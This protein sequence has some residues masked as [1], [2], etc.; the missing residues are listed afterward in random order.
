MTGWRFVISWRWAGYFALV[1]VFAIASCG[2]GNWQFDRRAQAQTE[3]QRIQ[4]NYEAD[5]VPVAEVLPQLDAWSDDLK[6]TPV[7][8][9][10][11]YL[12]DE[13]ILVRGRP[14][15]GHP[16]FEVLTPLQLDDGSV[17]V[18]NRG[19]V[20]I[21]SRQDNPDVVPEAPDGPVV[22]TAR[23][24][25]GEPTIEGKTAKAGSNQIATIR[26]PDVASR[27][28]LP[29]YTGAYGIVDSQDPRPAA[30]PIVAPKPELDEG[31]HLS[32]ALQWYVFALLAFIGLGWA[33]RQEYRVVNSTDP[34]V[35]DEERRRAQRKAKRAPS[36]AEIEDAMFD[37]A[38]TR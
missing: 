16:G 30:S 11:T 5:P 12:K 19:W 14:Y 22:V 36:D 26:L 10:G 4:T 25:A 17:F 21:G 27:L 1:V 6:W 29:T 31:P 38:A 3:I 2:F 37:E 9:K 13:E 28:G 18:V 23:L 15:S 20:A 24:K 32:Y 8:L 7:L 33:L 34:R 35:I